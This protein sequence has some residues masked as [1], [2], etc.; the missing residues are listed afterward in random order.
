MLINHSPPSTITL[1]LDAIV[2]L[3][4]ILVN[5]Q[6]TKTISGLHSNWWWY[7]PPRKIS[8][9]PRK[10]EENRLISHIENITSNGSTSPSQFVT[11]VVQKSFTLTIFWLF[12]FTAHLPAISC[13]SDAA[14]FEACKHHCNEVMFM[15]HTI[16]FIL[17]G[18]AYLKI[19]ANWK[20]M[21]HCK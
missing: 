3:S 1:G 11:A 16:S 19:Q 20:A 10:G 12:Y 4:Q 15:L 6:A 2:F 5:H 14:E 17:P 8:Q 13:C 21:V 9:R 18:G 7:S